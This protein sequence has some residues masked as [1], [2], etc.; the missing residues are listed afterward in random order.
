MMYNVPSDPNCSMILWILSVLLPKWRF[1]SA[2][3][4]PYFFTNKST[5]AAE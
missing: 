2:L 5:N 3:S 1:P 4:Q